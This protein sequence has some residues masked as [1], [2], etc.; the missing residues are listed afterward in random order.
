MRSGSEVRFDR[1]IHQVLRRRDAI[2]V[3]HRRRGGYIPRD[4]IAH[5]LDRDDNR[6]WLFAEL[7]QTDDQ[8]R[9]GAAECSVGLQRAL[10]LPLGLQG[11]RGECLRACL[12]LENATG[13]RARGLAG[14]VRLESE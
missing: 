11:P 3:S 10:T 12:L 14:L 5:R 9:D 6:L 1:P 13:E 2:S 8:F 7:A 4:L